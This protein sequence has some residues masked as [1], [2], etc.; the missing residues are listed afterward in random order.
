MV[1]NLEASSGEE[2]MYGWTLESLRDFSQVET[3]S[4]KGRPSLWVAFQPNC[5]SCK[6][7]LEQLSC[8]PS[9]I[10][11]VA[12]GVKGSREQLQKVLKGVKSDQMRL[13]ASEDLT[14][15]LK[16]TGTPTL[17]VVGPQGQIKKRILGAVACEQLLLQFKQN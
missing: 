1:L 8:L 15:T 13:R 3:A 7:Q 4:L 12:L 5:S 17:L 6:R 16:M 9:E 11:R 2:N 14:E 10:Q